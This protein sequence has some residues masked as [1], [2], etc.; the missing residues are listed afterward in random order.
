MASYPDSMPVGDARDQL[1]IEVQQAGG[2]TCP[3]C[4]QHA[5]V[6][7][8]SLYGTAVRALSLFYRLGGTTDFHHSRELKTYGHKGQ[9]DAS[10]LWKWGLL[11]EDPARRVDGGRAG[12]WRVTTLGEAF[13]FGRTT[14]PKYLYVYDNRVLAGHNSGGQVD[15]RTTLGKNFDYNEMMSG[16]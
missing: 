13:L 14:I 8:W 7:R 3:V 6:Y 12:F 9:G 5:Q 11:E 2:A 1:R 10:R 15:V 4:T 16:L